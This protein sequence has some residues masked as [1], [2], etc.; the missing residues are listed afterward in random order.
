MACRHLDTY[1]MV[2]IYFQVVTRDATK[3]DAIP[4]VYVI[5]ASL[6]VDSRLYSSAVLLENKSNELSISLP[7]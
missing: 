2:V 4:I 5:F 3:R 7:Q 6:R 1:E